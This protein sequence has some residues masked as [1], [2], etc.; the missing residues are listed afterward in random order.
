MKHFLLVALFAITTATT[1]LLS[2]DGGDARPA[3]T[4]SVI[5][6]QMEKME[7]ALDAVGDFLKKPE[8]AAPMDKITAAASS[9][10]EAKKHAPKATERMPKEKQAE[11][12]TAYQVEIN[13]AL[14]GI[15]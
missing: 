15:L 11:F 14:R 7:E 10:M 3:R 12:V 13:K 4:P 5:K 8:G 2:Q 9:L 1:P 6:E